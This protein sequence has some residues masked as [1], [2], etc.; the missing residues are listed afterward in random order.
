[1]GPDLAASAATGD[2]GDAVMQCYNNVMR[3]QCIFIG[4]AKAA[5]VEALRCS[6]CFVSIGSDSLQFRRL[7]YDVQTIPLRFRVISSSSFRTLIRFLA[8]QLL[9][10]TLL[11]TTGAFAA[12]QLNK[13]CMDALPLSTASQAQRHRAQIR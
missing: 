4:V 2:D 11:T 6:D 13:A 3:C 5:G 1:M 10:A 8:S 12:T 9:Q 7:I